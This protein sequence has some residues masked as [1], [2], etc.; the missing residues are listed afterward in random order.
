MV[1]Y[2]IYIYIKKN[3]NYNNSNIIINIDKLLCT[4]I[5]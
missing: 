2:C 1:I 5:Y 4:K 3:I